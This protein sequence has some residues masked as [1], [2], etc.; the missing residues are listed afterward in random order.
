MVA[1]SGPGVTIRVAE[2]WGPIN[3]KILTT[4]VFGNLNLSFWYVRGGVNDYPNPIRL[5]NVYSDK[6]FPVGKPVKILSK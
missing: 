4:L 6:S 2:N 3:N 5:L 1:G